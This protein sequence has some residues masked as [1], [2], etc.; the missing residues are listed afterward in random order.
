MTLDE[1]LESYVEHYSGLY[2][3][4]PEWEL[5]SPVYYLY[6]ENYEE[7][8]IA[9]VMVDRSQW[10]SLVEM[11]RQIC[12]EHGYHAY[13]NVAEGWAVLREKDGPVDSSD[14]NLGCAPSEHPDRK[15]VL[16]FVLGDRDGN[17]IAAIYNLDRKA[18]DP[19][20]ILVPQAKWRSGEPGKM[21]R[22]RWDLWPEGKAEPDIFAKFMQRVGQNLHD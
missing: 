7:K 8:A 5:S 21:S 16:N 15:E 13:M 22:D 3:K 1:I 12:D 2:A 4:D 11:I 14:L 18:E 19:T 6:D 9:P 10:D 17:R 20:K